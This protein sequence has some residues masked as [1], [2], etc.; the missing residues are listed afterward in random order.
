MTAE[1]DFGRRRDRRKA[2]AIFLVSFLVYV[3]PSRR[4]SERRWP[5]SST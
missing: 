3:C 1:P 4:F 2:L 5:R